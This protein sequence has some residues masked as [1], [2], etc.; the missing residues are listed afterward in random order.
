MTLVAERVESVF[1]A[2][3]LESPLI[4]FEF[5]ITLQIATNTWPKTELG[6]WKACANESSGEEKIR[7]NPNLKINPIRRDCGMAL[8]LLMGLFLDAVHSKANRRPPE[9]FGPRI[10]FDRT[11]LRT[12]RGFAAVIIQHVLSMEK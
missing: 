4:T 6:I 3:D 11:C 9:T 10:Q 7:N 12:D 8:L 2:L 1:F 5:G